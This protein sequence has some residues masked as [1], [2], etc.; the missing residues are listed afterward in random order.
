M[1]T[2]L[3]IVFLAIWFGSWVAIGGFFE[4]YKEFFS[5]HFGLVMMAGA[6]LGM[7]NLIIW[8]IGDRL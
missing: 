1:K 8:E 6:I 7:L 2:L 4:I 5:N 3:K